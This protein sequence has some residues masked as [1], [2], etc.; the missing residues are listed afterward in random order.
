MKNAIFAGTFDPIHEGHIDI[1]RRAAKLFDNL[2][3]AISINDMKES[4]PLEARLKHVRNEVATLQL[5]NVKVVINNGLTINAAKAYDCHFLVRSIRNANDAIYELDM[6]HQ[7]DLLANGI[8]TILFISD[9][10][11]SSVSSTN[12]REIKK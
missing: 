2:Y 9:L 3:V 6:A 8:E 4:S 10:E 12:V 5:D 11:F 1:I 7:N